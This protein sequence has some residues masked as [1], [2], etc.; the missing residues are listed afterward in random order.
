LL[1][2]DAAGDAKEKLLLEAGV[3]KRRILRLGS[4]R[5]SIVLEDLLDETVYLAAVN[6]ELGRWNADVQMPKN[7]LTTTGRPAVVE[8]WCK[9]QKP[10]LAVPSKRA[11]AHRVLE[12]GYKPNCRLVEAP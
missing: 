4:R 2:G 12:R 3:P 5:S 1:D 8:A 9:R 10:P 6:E 11:V 7:V